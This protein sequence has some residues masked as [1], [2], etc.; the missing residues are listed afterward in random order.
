MAIQKIFN[1]IGRPQDN[2]LI[3][4]ISNIDML[5]G[6]VKYVPQNAKKLMDEFWPGPLTIIMSKG[7]LMTMGKADELKKR[8]NAANLEEVFERVVLENE[9]H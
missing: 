4:H 7:K 9:V 1:A 5:N 8:Y 2:P 6:L 3:E